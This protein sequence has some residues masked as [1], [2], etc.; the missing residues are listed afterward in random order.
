MRVRKKGVKN[1]WEIQKVLGL[2]R[3]MAIATYGICAVLYWYHDVRAIV[4]VWLEDV[5]EMKRIK[6]CADYGYAQE[7]YICEDGVLKEKDG[8][9]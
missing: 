3:Y 8:K 5:G 1:E 4:C 9:E 7:G 6:R 2:Q